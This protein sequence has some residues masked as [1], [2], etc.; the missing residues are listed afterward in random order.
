M[1]TP[2]ATTVLKAFDL[3]ALFT[4]HP[5][6]GA[7]E[8]ARLV[9]APRASTHRMLVTLHA[10][11]VLDAD[12]DGQYRLGLRL[13]ELGV[14]API[15]R[16]MHR[17]ARPVLEALSS[18]LELSAALAVRHGDE[19]MWLEKV[20]RHRSDPR[21]RVGRRAPLHTTAAGKVL[22]AFAPSDV[23]R[24][25]VT[26]GIE[27]VTA[28]TMIEPHRLLAELQSVRETGIAWE[29]E[30]SRLGRS[31]IATRLRGR[32]GETVAAICL[33]T[34]TLSDSRRLG[35]AERRLVDAAATIERRMGGYRLHDQ[36]IAVSA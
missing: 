29:R 22:L 14:A 31:S 15:C 28:Y 19:L 9:G 13:F 1:P 23:I 10:A 7:S 20:R 30:E 6:L 34:T 35:S 27:R 12:D 26:T 2:P 5:Q 8:A 11:G 33:C 32:S 36:A 25:Y 17:N 4:E 16:R 18:D 3:L 21:P 24:R